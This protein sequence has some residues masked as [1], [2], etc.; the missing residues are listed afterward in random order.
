M[1]Q[2]NF[3]K[4]VINNGNAIIHYHVQQEIQLQDHGHPVA[5][6]SSG[7]WQISQNGHDKHRMSIL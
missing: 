6:T 3:I 1:K 4:G 5:N 2:G 7:H